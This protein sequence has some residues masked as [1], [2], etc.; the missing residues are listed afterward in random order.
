MAQATAHK[1]DDCDK[2]IPVYPNMNGAGFKS[3][4]SERKLTETNA[5]QVIDRELCKECALK[6]FAKAYPGKP[7]PVLG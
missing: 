4:T 2:D 6:D 5:V 3:Y 7:L 1:C